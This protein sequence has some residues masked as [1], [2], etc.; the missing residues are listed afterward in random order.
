MSGAFSVI[1]CLIIV[2]HFHGSKIDLF[3]NFVSSSPNKVISN[4]GM[5]HQ[6]S[7]HSDDIDDLPPP[8]PSPP[9][10]PAFEDDEPLPPVPEYFQ[11]VDGYGDHTGSFDL[12][13][14]ACSIYSSE[15]MLDEKIPPA[16][17]NKEELT[18]NGLPTRTAKST[19]VV[20][21]EDKFS[22]DHAA[23]PGVSDV[24]QQ[25]HEG[26]SKVCS[27]KSQR[28]S[29]GVH[30]QARDA[31]RM[32]S[33]GSILSAQDGDEEHKRKVRVSTRKQIN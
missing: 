12:S 5:F 19:E 32:D 2:P 1:V 28:V 27:P 21:M 9:P 16:A 7:V 15:E 33:E 11:D 18:E 4:A 23:S 10:P 3:L 24:C 6:S 22:S 25:N 20:T 8:P 13:M 14:K 17:S 30:G 31:R 26:G 29:E